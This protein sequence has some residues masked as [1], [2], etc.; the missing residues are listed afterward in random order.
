V[1]VSPSSGI[2][3]RQEIFIFVGLQEEIDKAFVGLPDLDFEH[4]PWR[5]IL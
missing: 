1:G 2:L 3:G 5:E 4:V